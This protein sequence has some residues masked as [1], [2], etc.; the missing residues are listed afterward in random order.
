MDE[1]KKTDAPKSPATKPMASGEQ[2]APGAQASGSD[3][4]PA[5][6]I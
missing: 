5:A 4:V 6:K 2:G 1:T 3:T